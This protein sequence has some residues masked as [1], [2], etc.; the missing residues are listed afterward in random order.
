MV[1]KFMYIPN[2]D[3]QNYPLCRLKPN[4]PINQNSVNV[5]TNKSIIEKLLGLVS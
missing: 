2:N 5:P 1:N 3:T 4:K